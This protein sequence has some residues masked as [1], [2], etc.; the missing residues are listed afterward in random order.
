MPHEET[1]A[2]LRKEL[3]ESRGRIATAVCRV[4]E[5]FGGLSRLGDSPELDALRAD[6]VAHE[7]VRRKYAEAIA[8]VDIARRP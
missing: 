2:V 5:R 6:V 4:V 7:L 1:L 3:E 8:A